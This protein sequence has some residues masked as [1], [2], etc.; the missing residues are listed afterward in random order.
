MR[1]RTA[2]GYAA[3]TWAELVCPLA[4]RA[5][6]ANDHGTHQCDVL[7]RWRRLHELDTILAATYL[8]ARERNFGEHA[9]FL[10][11][12]FV[13]VMQR[14]GARESTMACVRRRF[15][16]LAE[17]NL[18]EIEGR[19]QRVRMGLAN[20]RGWP[21]GVRRVGERLVQAFNAWTDACGHAQAG[22]PLRDSDTARC[23]AHMVDAGI[24]PG[25]PILQSEVLNDMLHEN[26]WL[27]RRHEIEKIVA[28]RSFDLR[29]RT[30]VAI[31]RR[32]DVLVDHG[33]LTV[34]TS[35]AKETTLTLTRKGEI[36]HAAVHRVTTLPQ[37]A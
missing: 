6:E 37:V 8:E 34:E 2:L 30:R 31:T 16:A 1:H 20:Y 35:G 28:R 23:F 5:L 4:E 18:V 21:E 27:S 32:R 36:L 24:A 17:F 10:L 3:D 25:R 15:T 11:R 9:P 19:P 12:D 26:R 13:P 29:A 22:D 7:A 33:V 14:G